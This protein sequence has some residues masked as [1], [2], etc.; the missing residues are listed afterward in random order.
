M[1]IFEVFDANGE[2]ISADE[3]SSKIGADKLLTGT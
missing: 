2:A 1:R 3:L